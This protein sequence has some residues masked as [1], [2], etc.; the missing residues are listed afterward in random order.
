[1]GKSQAKDGKYLR[2]SLH[3]AFIHY[4]LIE[5]TFLCFEV[6][7]TLLPTFQIDVYLPRACHLFKILH[8]GNTDLGETF[9]LSPVHQ[10]VFFFL[11]RSDFAFAFVPWQVFSPSFLFK[12]GLI[13]SSVELF[14][15]DG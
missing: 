9:G 8:Q 15:V 5:N 7:R 4:I 12:Q 2:P 6:V 10:W 1:M 3:L 14:Y 11:L 13:L